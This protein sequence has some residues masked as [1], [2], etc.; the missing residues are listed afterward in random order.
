MSSSTATSTNPLT[1]RPFSANYHTVLRMS[2]ELP[3]SQNMPE[4]LEAIKS[5]NVVILSGETGSGK[6]TQVPKAILLL[7]EIMEQVSGGKVSVTQ[8]RRLAAQL[9]C[10]NEAPN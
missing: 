5:H 6:T 1:G 9:V 3:V 10:L 2:R 4:I 7:A 8:N